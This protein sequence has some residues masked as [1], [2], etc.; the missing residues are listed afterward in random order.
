MIFQLNVRD[1]NDD[2]QAKDYC[3][4]TLPTN[5]RKYTALHKTRLRY[6]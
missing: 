1:N 6:P 2:V 5:T 3:V 4:M